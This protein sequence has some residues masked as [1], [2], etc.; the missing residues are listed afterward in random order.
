M[1]GQ[2][3][4]TYKLSIHFQSQ[5][6]IKPYQW[7]TCPCQQQ[8]SNKRSGHWASERQ[9][10]VMSPQMS[11]HILPD[12]AVREN[13]MSSLNVERLLD[14]GVGRKDELKQYACWDEQRAEN[15]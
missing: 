7:P 4:N 5:H 8:G 11:I 15:V 2:E 12:D 10:V 13:V 3:G 1:K 14:L 9:M 6:I